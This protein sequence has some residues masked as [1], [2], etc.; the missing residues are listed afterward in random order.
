[1]SVLISLYVHCR[2]L[3]RNEDNVCCPTLLETKA[4]RE[5][6]VADFI[7]AHNVILPQ[8]FHFFSRKGNGDNIDAAGLP[9]LSE[10]SPHPVFPPRGPSPYTF[11]GWRTDSSMGS[12]QPVNKFG[13]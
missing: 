6:G 3:I 11:E 5:A 8:S 4:R 10:G 12:S 2:W 9:G 1:M 7:S 13:K